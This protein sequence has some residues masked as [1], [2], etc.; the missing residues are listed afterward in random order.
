MVNIFYGK[1]CLFWDDLWLNNVPRIHY[2][3]LYSFA[4]NKSISLFEVKSAED[5]G[6]FLQLPLSA[7][8]ADQLIEL[9]SS[10]ISLPETSNTDV[11]SYMWGSPF[12]STS[13]AYGHLTGSRPTHPIFK[14]LWKSS[15][16]NKHRVFFWLLLHD[17]LST[18]D[19]L[20][21][22][23][24]HLPSYDCVCCNLSMAET[25]FHHFFDCPFALACWS[26]LQVALAGNSSWQVLEFIKDQFHFLSLWRL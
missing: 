7:Q 19:L 10:L 18:R 12:F 17:R 11:W 1:S 6:D 5:Y 9:A 14:W 15:C 13:K 2:P 22:R 24:M 20:R 23:N 16:Q 8:A 3:Q 25:S 21:Q 26:R 4:K